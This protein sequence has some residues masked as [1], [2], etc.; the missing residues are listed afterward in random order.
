MLS[1]PSM[2]TEKPLSV[3][4]GELKVKLIDDRWRIDD[5]WW[6][7]KP[8]SRMYYAIVLE[9]GQQ[10]VVY[11]DLINNTWYR[12]NIGKTSSRLSK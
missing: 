4:K 6:R 10:M 3:G 7:T 1:R 2:V 9:T 5:E 11:K 8:I 12:Q